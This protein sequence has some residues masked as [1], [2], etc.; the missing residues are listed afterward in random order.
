MEHKCPKDENHV[1]F[2]CEEAPKSSPH[3]AAV[4][5]KECDEHIKWA[6]GA[7]WNSYEKTLDMHRII[8]TKPYCPLS[9]SQCM[10][11][12]C[13]WWWK[14]GAELECFVMRIAKLA[15]EYSYG[16]TDG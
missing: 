7:E 5:C 13:A 12:D 16:E 10:E 4:L 9:R 15:V 2:Y 3:Y 6:T 8:P 14:F 11:E 1:G